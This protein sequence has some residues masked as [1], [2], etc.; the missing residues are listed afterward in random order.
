MGKIGQYLYKIP[1]AKNAANVYDIGK[2]KGE[3]PKAMA[4]TT[5]Q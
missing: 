3:R 4:W 2:L 1:L 5:C